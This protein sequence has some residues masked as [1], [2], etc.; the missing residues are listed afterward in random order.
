MLAERYGW[1]EQQVDAMDPDY[2]TELA[3]FI[4]ADAMI[5]HKHR[6]KKK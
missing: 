2:R 6:P 1:T 3:A 4:A 5:K